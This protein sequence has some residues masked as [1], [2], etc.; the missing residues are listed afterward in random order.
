MSEAWFNF[1]DLLRSNG[2]IGGA[3][4]H[5]LQALKIDPAYADAIYNLA[6]LEYDAGELSQA[7]HWW[8]RYLLIDRESPWARTA[9]RGIEFVDTELRRSSG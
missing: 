9:A 8:S 6:A 3:R 2:K 7:R 4:H 1:A 5:L